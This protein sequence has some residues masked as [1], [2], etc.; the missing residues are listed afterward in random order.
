MATRIGDDEGSGIGSAGD[1][2]E[3]EEEEEDEEQRDKE[4]EVDLVGPFQAHL[5]AKAEREELEPS[6]SKEDRC[7][8]AAAAAAEDG[9]MVGMDE[10]EEVEEEAAR[11]WI[12]ALLLREVEEKVLD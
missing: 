6:K 10:S 9:L 8:V 12:V 5:L 11:L 3:E 4:E 1:E 2:E 7:A